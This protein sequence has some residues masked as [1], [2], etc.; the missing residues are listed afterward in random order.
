MG[1]CYNFSAFKSKRMLDGNKIT[2]AVE[3]GCRK[4]SEF[5]NI[6]YRRVDRMISVA[7]GFILKHSTKDNNVYVGYNYDW[8]KDAQ[9]YLD[10][11]ESF[12]TVKKANEYIAIYNNAMFSENASELYIVCSETKEYVNYSDY[13]KKFFGKQ[14]A[15]DMIGYIFN[16]DVFNKKGTTEK[17]A[18]WYRKAVYATTDIND[19][20]SDYTDVIADFE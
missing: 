17:L 12:I 16:Q 3:S 18:N 11:Q 5:A 15:L 14:R 9:N 7:V 2:A 4:L 19:I 8:A 1:I 20:A 6:E 13:L 10:A